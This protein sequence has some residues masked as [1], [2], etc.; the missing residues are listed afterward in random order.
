MKRRLYLF[1]LGLV[2]ILNLSANAVTQ[3]SLEATYKS[4][5]DL[6]KDLFNRISAFLENN[7]QYKTPQDLYFKLAD[8]STQIYSDQPDTVLSLYKKVLA[9]DPGFAYK[10]VVLYNIGYFSSFIVK[11]SRDNKRR[12]AIIDHPEYAIQWPDSLLLS[13]AT[14]YDALS[15]YS[16]LINNYR[17]SGLYSESLFRLALLYYDI[18]LDSGTPITYY[19]KANELL[20]TLSQIDKDQYR[21]LSIFQ[22]AWINMNKGDFNNSIEQFVVVLKEIEKSDKD[23]NYFEKDALEN[24]SYCLANLDA[25]DYLSKSKTAEYI[26]TNFQKHNLAS[27]YQDDILKRIVKF[28]LEWNAPM[29]A[30]DVYNAILSN[31]PLYVQNPVLIDSI[32]TIY[33]KYPNMTR[34]NANPKDLILDQYFRLVKDYNHSSLWYQ[35]NKNEDLKAPLKIISY[36]FNFIE[37]VLLNRFAG[38]RKDVDYQTFVSFEDDFLSYPELF[39]SSAYLQASYDKK[40]RI[41]NMTIEM[42][43]TQQDPAYYYLAMQRINEFNQQ[44]PTNPKFFEN[45]VSVYTSAEILYETY[46][47]KY[48]SQP[49][50][51]TF[52]NI[53]L[54]AEQISELY[55]ASLQKYISIL[56]SAPNYSLQK[57]PE[58][59]DL[60]MR[61]IK[62]D[63]GKG[64]FEQVKISYVKLLEYPLDKKMV[65]YIYDKLA[66]LSQKDKNYADAEKYYRLAEGQ[67]EIKK[68]KLIYRNNYLAI[69]QTNADSLRSL[70][71]MQEAGN[72]Y[73]KLAKEVDPAD[74]ANIQAQTWNAVLCFKQ[75][76]QYE[77]AIELVQKIADTKTKSGEAYGF[78]QFSWNIADSLMLNKTKGNALRQEYMSKY[79]AALETYS[80]RLKIVDNLGTQDSTKTQAAQAYLQL[81]DD[82]M[83][84][85]VNIGKD[86]PEDLYLKAIQILETSPDKELYYSHL[87]KFEKLYP[88]HPMVVDMLTQVLLHY[89]ETGKNDEYEKMAKYLFKK[90]KNSPYYTEIANQKLKVIYTAEDSCYTAKDYKAMLVKIDD[91]QKAHNFYKAEGMSFDLTKIYEEFANH[92]AEYQYYLAEQ[93]FLKQFD[94][95][96]A[97]IRKDYKTNSAG[98][99][100]PIN[101]KTT[102]KKDMQ[103][104]YL[105]QIVKNTDKS[106]KQV[107]A[108]LK[109]AN[110]NKYKIPVE[111]RIEAIY[112]IAEIYEQGHNMM[113]DLVTKYTNRSRE[114]SQFKSSPEVFQQ[115]SEGILGK[116]SDYGLQANSATYMKKYIY[117]NYA[118]LYEHDKITLAQNKLI[119]WGVIDSTL[120]TEHQPDN[121]WTANSTSLTDSLNISEIKFSVPEETANGTFAFISIQ[122]QVKW[123]V[124][125]DFELEIDPEL[126][127]IKYISPQP[128]AITANKG[129]IADEADLLKDAGKQGNL[130]G[131]RLGDNFRKG[132]NSVQF[133]GENN[134]PDTL[135]IGVQLKSI[136]NKRM[137]DFARNS[138]VIN[139]L[140]NNTWLYVQADSLTGTDSL[141]WK[142]VSKNLVNLTPEMVT[143]MEK[144]KAEFIWTDSLM[145]Q[146]P[147]FFKT[148][149]TLNNTVISSLMRFVATGQASIWLNGNP[150]TQESAFTYDPASSKAFAETI[151]TDTAF[152]VAGINTIIIKVNPIPDNNWKGIY[153][154]LQ[155]TKMK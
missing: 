58:L 144:T 122:P 36:A 12:S 116:L 107:T 44:Y 155:Y 105:K 27:A 143:G 150:L 51:N 152:F 92:K 145:N 8:L 148:E 41:V 10:D 136:F 18:A 88:N 100:M 55:Y 53:S 120:V 147:L 49:Y 57:L 40:Q 54:T 138:E 34:N 71:K 99:Y 2:F 39:D 126:C 90:D 81:H 22:N 19:N 98:L 86:K 11:E 119:Q 93:E 69:I 46:A 47:P 110:E 9:L 135:R 97:Q 68:D 15:A 1:L 59:V 104:N 56:G 14:L 89:K 78:Y 142:Q 129:K 61:K 95:S 29:Q 117:D 94:I 87:L 72:E 67:T 111:K 24:I 91:F 6:K 25:T 48:T 16:E 64:N 84:G 73:L 38:N 137:L 106:A 33:R 43:V 112:A 4:N 128:V 103:N 76:G 133:N 65:I 77:Q 124:N 80:I 5:T 7:P 31:R 13:E 66:Q 23:K 127:L 63:T 3:Q 149:F 131:I 109:K 83:N 74:K 26:S 30:I 96:L 70:G 32:I 118:Y 28:K 134:S 153:F 141:Q 50:T 62:Y 115:Y 20:T 42:S 21:L 114:F 60:Y 140:S 132:S 35:T 139:V 151:E 52:F 123:S 102:W 17:T 146:K 154:D 125:I 82:S 37:P 75:G 130:Y 79:P 121:K 45:E 108:L 101:P 113:V 85:K